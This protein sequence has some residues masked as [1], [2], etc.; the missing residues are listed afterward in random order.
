[1]DVGFLVLATVSLLVTVITAIL[2]F[3]Y[4][5][6][7]RRAGCRQCRHLKHSNIFKLKLF[8]EL[9]YSGVS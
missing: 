3:I 7:S 8:K 9:P 4:K 6:R 5:R 2:D 1:M